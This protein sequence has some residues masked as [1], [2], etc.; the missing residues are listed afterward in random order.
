VERRLGWE[1]RKRRFEK[2]GGRGWEGE[3]WD[4]WR[5]LFERVVDGMD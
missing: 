4:D 1:L 5:V 2:I 3:G